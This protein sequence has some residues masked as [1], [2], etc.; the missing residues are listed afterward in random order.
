M[1]ANNTAK[2]HKGFVTT[3]AEQRFRAKY[4]VSDGCWLWTGTTQG[5]GAYPDFWD[6]KRHVR[7][8]RFAWEQAFGPIPDGLVVMHTCDQPLCVRPV[9]LRLGTQADNLRDMA[10]K[11]RSRNQHTVA[12]ALD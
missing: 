12:A 4:I 6:G 7:G 5:R 2:G 9:H 1:V 3:P 8:H 11:G 10:T